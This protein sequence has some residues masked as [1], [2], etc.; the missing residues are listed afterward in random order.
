MK[1]KLVFNQ[2]HFVPLLLIFLMTIEVNAQTN[3]AKDLKSNKSEKNYV[4]MEKRESI[5]DRKVH[6]LDSVIWEIPN[7]PRLCDKLKLQKKTIDIGGCNL[8]VEE[9]GKGTPIV[10][11]HGGPGSTHIEF[12]PAFDQFS[13]FA[14]II[15]YDQRGCGLSDYKP[16]EGYS[17]LQAAND[18]DR[19]REKLGIEKWVVLG[20]SYG[21]FLAQ[22]YT[23]LFPEHVMGLVIVNGSTGLH[24]SVLQDTRSRDFISKD[25]RSAMNRF[26]KEISE[27]AKNE[28]WSEEKEVATDIYNAFMNGDWK[29]QSF[30]RPTEEE[31]AQ[32]AL[33]SWKNDFKNNFNGYMGY[34]MRCINLKGL[35]DECPVPTLIMESVWDLT[36]E[37]SKAHLLA[38]NHPNAGM[39]VFT[40]SGHSPFEDEPE[41]FFRALKDFTGKLKPVPDKLIS[42]YKTF[43]QKSA[44]KYDDPYLSSPISDAEAREIVRFQSAFK[45]IKEGEKYFDLSSPLNSLLSLYSACRDSDYTRIDKIKP[46]YKVTP[47]NLNLFISWCEDFYPWRAPL[48]P[49]K[50]NPGQIWPVYMKSKE[51]DKWVDTFIF[52]YWNGSWENQGNMSRPYVNWRD[53]EEWMQ[54]EYLIYRLQNPDK[55]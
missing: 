17:V 9:Q 47:E 36:W 13:K 43:V 3:K 1:N 28:N 44:D 51:T 45:G 49:S 54:N 21:G 22:Y 46:T 42:E 55:K 19:L 41:I 20:F 40:R 38:K 18:L 33:Y 52:Q 25:E 15:Y 14:R 6:I 48:P 37:E 7:V 23:T 29:R 8:Y 24:N 32:A 11:I 10:L 35:F 4:A 12:H 31:I 5:L 50:P 2:F 30:Y 53:L 16:E 27:K 39:V 34:S 26:R